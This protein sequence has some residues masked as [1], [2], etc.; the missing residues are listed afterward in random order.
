M[1]SSQARSKS[2]ETPSLSEDARVK[3][4]QAPIIYPARPLG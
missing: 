2:W 3:L 4:A 1:S